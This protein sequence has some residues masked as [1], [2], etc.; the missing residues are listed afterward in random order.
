V[1]K[2]S[3]HDSYIL[4]VSFFSDYG[5]MWL[6]DTYTCLLI[7]CSNLISIIEVKTIVGEYRWRFR[8][9]QRRI[10]RFFQML[11]IESNA[12]THHFISSRDWSQISLQSRLNAVLFR[13]AHKCK[14]CFTWAASRRILI[15]KKF[16]SFYLANNLDTTYPTNQIH[17]FSSA[18]ILNVHHFTTL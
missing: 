17:T 14:Q 12:S 7:A 5:H 3:I 9:N 8:A 18:L 4:S 15:G 2:I 1:N 10:G 16:T 13:I 6:H 11:S